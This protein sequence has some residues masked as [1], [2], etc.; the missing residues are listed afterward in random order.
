MRRLLAVLAIVAVA[1]PGLHADAKTKI[2]E[3]IKAE[4]R[5]IHVVHEKLNAKR[6]QLQDAKH[7]VGSLQEQLQATNR[8]IAAVNGTL[9]VL[10][11]RMRST[12]KKLAWNHV[13]LDAARKTLQRH[14]EALKRRLIDAYEHGDLG[15]I[16]VLLESRSFADFVERW[17][18]IRYIIKANETTIRQ[19]RTVE[20]QVRGIERSLLGV[21]ALL[22]GEQAQARQ[23]RLALDALA[24]QRKDLLA[25]ANEQRAAVAQEVAQLDE[26]S[27]EEETALENL[28]REKQREE[29]A[30]REAERRARQLAGEAVPPVAGA[31]GSV[32]WPVSGAIT[33]PFGM[34]EHPVLGGIRAHTG[35]DIAASQGTTI[36]AA[37]EG[38]IIVAGWT[39]GGYGNMVVIDHGGS[40]STLYG[41]MSA[42]FVG[43]GQ[44]VQRGQAIGAVGSTGRSTGPHLHFE[45]RINGVPV[46]PMSYLR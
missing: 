30:R 35:I 42:V 22:A 45:V 2:D 15:Y 3:K 33:S 21:Q 10:G 7:R 8:N 17:N 5:K 14:N 44:D 11:A 43:A 26:I 20:A 39:D 28:I 36:A 13:Q 16:D 24:S 6:A 12:E 38:R 9:A 34:R 40:M 27:Q 23:Q 4:Q 18:D 32:S 31:P 25:Q 41:H 19:R 37:A 1:A 46:D 29:A